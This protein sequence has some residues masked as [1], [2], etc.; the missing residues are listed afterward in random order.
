MKEPT[1]PRLGCGAGVMRPKCLFE[2]DPS[3]CPRLPLRTQYR[4]LLLRRKRPKY[5]ALLLAIQ[6]CR[7][8]ARSLDEYTIDRKSVV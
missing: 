1:C 2:L 5:R 7:R 3:E 8:M 4:Q 6:K